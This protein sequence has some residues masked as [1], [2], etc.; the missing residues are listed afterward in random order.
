M[1]SLIKDNGFRVLFEYFLNEFDLDFLIGKRKPIGNKEKTINNVFGKITDIV[2]FVDRLKKYDLYFNTVYSKDSLIPDEEV[3][4]YHLHNYMQDWYVLQLR[5]RELMGVL[6]NSL[7]HFNIENP[8]DVKKALDSIKINT[9]SGLKKITDLR[10]QNVHDSSVRDLDLS[11]AKSLILYGKKRKVS[12]C[13]TK[14][15]RN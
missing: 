14:Q 3:V 2:S 8:E 15:K 1:N 9:E 5:I 13:K 10:G 4:E 7:P 12:S 11:K 6:K